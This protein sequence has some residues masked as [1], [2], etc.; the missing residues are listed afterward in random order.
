MPTYTFQQIDYPG[1]SGDNSSFESI[2]DAGV[3]AGQAQT[4]F[5]SSND[6]ETDTGFLYSSGRFS[7]APIIDPGIV[8]GNLT[9]HSVFI[10]GENNSGSLV[11]SLD[12]VGMKTQ[13]AISYTRIES[14]RLSA[15]PEP[16]T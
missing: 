14:S 12:D 8:Y 13:V 11:G 1:V 5:Q 10:Y 16:P 15:Y 7:I 2:N 9:F 6:S 4:S 3:A